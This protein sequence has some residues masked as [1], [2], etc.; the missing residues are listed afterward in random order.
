MKKTLCAAVLA[1][2]LMA[3]LS[4]TQ[5]LVWAQESGD[6]EAKY[7]IKEVMTQAHKEG[8]IQKV[9][10]GEATAEEKAK[11][12]DLYLS[13]LEN[14]PPQGDAVDFKEKASAAVVAAA[15]VVVGREDAEAR[16]RRGVDCAG[17]HREH[18]PAP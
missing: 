3:I 9:E 10:K 1:I 18:R 14:D 17:C 12:L 16:V 13:L 5:A 2:L 4:L 6:S 15:R 7:T 11:L 8:L